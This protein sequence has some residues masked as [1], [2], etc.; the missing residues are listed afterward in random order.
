MPAISRH[1]LTPHEIAEETWKW[2]IDS[3]TLVL[4]WQFNWTGAASV[5]RLDT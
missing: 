4:I 3:Q 2:E 5:Q 1:P